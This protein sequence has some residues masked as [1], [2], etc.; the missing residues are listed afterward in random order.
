MFILRRFL[1]VVQPQLCLVME[2]ELWPNMVQACAKNGT[3]LMVV[4]ARLSQRSARGYFRARCLSVPML[5]QI[6]FIAAQERSD[7]L[8]FKALGVQAHQ[9]DVTGTIK[10]DVRV[11]E[12]QHRQAQTWRTQAGVDRYVVIAA[13]THEG[14][15]E[16][17]L[18]AFLAL[19]KSVTNAMLILVPRHPERF[20]AVTLLA[21][22][23]GLKVM[24]RSK[25][26]L[27]ADTDILLGDTMGELM[28]LYGVADAAFVGGSLVARGGHN[29]LEPLAWGIPVAQG[30]HTFNFATLNKRLHKQQ[31]T[32]LVAGAPSLAEFWRR[33]ADHSTRVVIRRHANDFM[34]SAGGSLERVLKHIERIGKRSS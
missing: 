33:M 5:R 23:T 27:A 18:A 6:H 12:S 4:N 16:I 1:R 24:C 7:A 31:L 22:Q 3:P 32:A 29:P 30:A 21:E 2:T 25:N 28:S 11:L 10:S 15:D 9:M 14:E 8:R 26:E 13:S 17:V 34:A 19:K 20:K